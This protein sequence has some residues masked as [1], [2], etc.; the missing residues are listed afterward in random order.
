MWLDILWRLLANPI[1]YIV[2]QMVQLTIGMSRATSHGEV[3]VMDNLFAAIYLEAV[4]SMHPEFASM[5]RKAWFKLGQKL[6]KLQ[7]ATTSEMRRR[8]SR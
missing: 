1:C 4:Y 6:V 2:A 7:R 5:T 8:I 3:N